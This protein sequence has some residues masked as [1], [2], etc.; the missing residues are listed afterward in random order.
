M[1]D[2]YTITANTKD[3]S[4]VTLEIEVPVET[5][6]KFREDAVKDIS[7]EIEI[8]GFRK[9]TAPEKMIIDRVGEMAVTEKVAYRAINNIVPIVLS[10]EKLDALTMPGI[11]ITKIAVG[12]PLVF[13]MEVTLLPTVELPDYKKIARE[14]AIETIDTID[15]KDV[16]EY[17]EYLRKQRAHAEAMSKGEKIDQDN[18]EL[19]AFDDAFVATLGNFKT[20]DEFKTELRKNMLEERQ[21]RATETRRLKIMEQVIDATTIDVP[22]VLVEQELDRMLA[23][24]KHDIERFKMNPEDYLKELKKT[25]EDLKNEWRTDAV[26]R[27][28]MNL[29]LPKIAETENITADEKEIEHEL[30]HL[31]KHDKDINDAHA[32]MY[33]RLVLTN[34][35][36]FKF[37]EGVK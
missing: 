13:K 14:V 1:Q 15:E 16:D 4:K 32:R 34:E 5:L 6:G 21:Q 12:A 22:D 27:A 23:K 7:K 9:G 30:E 18:L 33:L 31:K 29:I 25:E 11:T 3:G 26:K 28:K 2:T 17:I 20:V 35:G 19:P 36:V 8:D 24:F 37:L 10:N